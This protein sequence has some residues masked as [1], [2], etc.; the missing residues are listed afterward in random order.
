MAG[1]LMASIS[2]TSS[3]AVCGA[4]SLGLATTALPAAMAATIGNSSN[5]TG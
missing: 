4:S 5:C 3:A 1:S 2:D